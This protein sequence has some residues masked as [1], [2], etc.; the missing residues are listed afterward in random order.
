MAALRPWPKLLA[1]V[2][3]SFRLLGAVIFC[4]AALGQSWAGVAVGLGTV[5]LSE[6]LL[7]RILSRRQEIPTGSSPE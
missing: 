7:G 6:W 2:V 3:G 4:L 5:A 1:Y